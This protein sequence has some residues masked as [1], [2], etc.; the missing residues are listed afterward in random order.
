MIDVVPMADTMNFCANVD[1]SRTVQSGELQ[2]LAHQSSALPVAVPLARMQSHV[3][4]A[5]KFDHGQRVPLA[6]RAQIPAHAL[7]RHLRKLSRSMTCISKE[8]PP[9]AE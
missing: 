7:R 5:S 8:Q 6:V 3:E 2:P 1:R 9:R 4:V